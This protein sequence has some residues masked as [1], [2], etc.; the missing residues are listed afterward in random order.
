MEADRIFQLLGIE[1]TKDEAKIKQAYRQKLAEVNPEVNPEGFKRLRS[2][3]EEA[4]S[5]ARKEEAD[6]IE[7]D[8]V[9]CLI[10]RLNVMYQSLP[11]RLDTS[12][13]E[14]LLG[15]ALFDDLEL[16]EKAKWKVFSYLMDHFRLPYTIWRILDGRFSIRENEQEFKE[17]LPTNFVDFMLWKS[18]EQGAEGEFPYEWFEGENRADYDGFISDYN[19][20]VNLTRSE[21]EAEDRQQWERAVEE[22]IAGMDSYH[23]IHP[24]FTLEKAKYAFFL[25]K[26]DE[27]GRLIHELWERYEEDIHLLLWGAIIL[28]DCGEEKKAEEAFHKLLECNQDKNT[29]FDAHVELGKIHLKRDELIEAREH[30]LDASDIYHNTVV[31]EL[32]TECNSRLIEF[33]THREGELSVQEG[34]RLAWCYIQ[35]RRAEEGYSW[36]A[37]HPILTEDSALC[38]RAKAILYMTG[39]HIEEA[40]EET[41]LWQKAWQQEE[42]RDIDKEAQ[43]FEVEGRCLVKQY[44]ELKKKSDSKGTSKE[45]EK[46]RAS[47]FAAFDKALDILPQSIDMLMSKMLFCREV[48]EYTIMAEL[49]EKLMNLDRTFFWGPF[50]A[51]EAY[52]KLGKAQ[53]VVDT[54]YAA[55]EIFAGQPEIY[56]RAARVFRAYNQFSEVES[57]LRQADEAGVDS[58]YLKVRRLEIQRR[59]AKEAE[60][61]RKTDSYAEE[62]I[63][64]LEKKR[65]EQKE[66]IPDELLADAYMQRAYLQDEAP[67]SEQKLEVMKSCAFQALKLEKSLRCRYFIGRYFKVYENDSPAAYDHLKT[68]EEQGMEFEWLDFYLARCQEAFEH[69]NEAISYYK[70]AMEKNPEEIDFA[71]RIGQ[72]YQQKFSRTGQREYYDEAI[73]YMDIQTNKFGADPEDLWLYATLYT[74]NGEFL[75]ALVKIEEAMERDSGVKFRG[76]KGQLLRMLGRNK[77][78]LESL[79]KAIELTREND[80]DYGFGYAQ[81]KKIF[82]DTDEQKEGIRW[83]NAQMPHLKSNEQRI[84]NLE[85]IKELYLELGDLEH[86]LEVIKQVNGGTSLKQFVHTSWE[87]EGERVYNLLEAYRKCLPKE[88]LV[89]KV[90]EAV[91]LMQNPKGKR[92]KPYLASKAKV[93]HKLG[94]IYCNY[95]QEDTKG[96]YYYQKALKI[97]DEKRGTSAVNILLL[98][99]IMGCQWRQGWLEMNQPLV[100]KFLEKIEN[101]YKEGLE[102]NKSPEELYVQDEKDGKMNLYYI[103]LVY[104]YAGKYDKANEYLK[105]LEEARHCVNCVCEV[106]TEEWECRGYWAL[107]QKATDRAKFCFQKALEADKSNVDAKRELE[108]LNQEEDGKI[109]DQPEEKG[110]SGIFKKLLKK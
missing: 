97:M 71:W 95:F 110:L 20:L 34:I 74:E 14:E 45:A 52:E 51:Q 77:E 99:R 100:Q 32:L 27:A 6:I 47:A 69:W 38:H 36:F 23:I 17:H 33:Y 82:G 61:Y 80:Q 35:T 66:E 59:N 30:L 49:C 15:E 56:D 86:A 42:E 9:S 75:R 11:D 53:E 70:R 84:D 105:R 44:V 5:L 39:N 18:S 22:K 98:V 67:G 37:D 87:E 68:C 10:R 29:V 60:D 7:E 54:F 4:L 64:E 21:K 83:F 63:K 13:W 1:E 8:E 92:L 24:W 46:L 104:F 93:F 91:K 26:K 85:Y 57:I 41:R 81:I 48:E 50:Y 101:D 106:C 58:P 72:L 55:K 43:S 12:Q 88:E 90:N 94:D 89:V 25:G 16:G 19:E 3:Y 96:L 65:N 107:Y 31:E 109:P 40:L 78:A 2:A 103:F 73:K 76:R 108:C 28:N 79:T 102:L 62:L